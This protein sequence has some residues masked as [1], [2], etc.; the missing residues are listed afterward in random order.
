[1]A[2]KRDGADVIAVC[3][4]NSYVNP[5]HEQRAR[6]VIEEVS[7]DVRVELSSEV[8]PLLREYDRAI[9]LALNAYVAPM[10]GVYLG[11]IG[12]EIR[13]RGDEQTLYVMHS[14]GEVIDSE[15]ARLFP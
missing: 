9:T 14:A 1:E 10:V 12:E 5:T 4:I 7:P 11:K 8:A 13:G 3:F 6:D 15:A 2:F